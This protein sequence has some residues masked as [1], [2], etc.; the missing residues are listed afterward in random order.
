MAQRPPHLPGCEA[1]CRAAVGSVTVKATSGNCHGQFIAGDKAY[2][3]G[4]YHISPPNALTI[5]HS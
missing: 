3:Q 4:T 1:Q 5:S 2:I